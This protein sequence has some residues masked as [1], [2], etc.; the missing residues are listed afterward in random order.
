MCSQYID[1]AEGRGTYSN[2]LPG[3]MLAFKAGLIHRDFSDGNVMIMD[4]GWFQ[5]FLL[6]LDY[7]FDWFEALEMA[8]VDTTDEAAWARFVDQ[9]NSKVAR[10]RR[11]GLSSQRNKIS[12]LFGKDADLPRTPARVSWKERMQMKE[13][14][15]RPLATLQIVFILTL[16]RVPC[17]SRLCKY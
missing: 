2:R 14:T 9:H 12:A 16:V 7:A 5:G 1:T 3:H 6:D 10:Y 13:R 8:G 4:G 11:F 15:V 17:S